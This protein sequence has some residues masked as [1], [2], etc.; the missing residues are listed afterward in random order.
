M[1]KRD[2]GNTLDV[3]IAAGLSR[4]SR[5]FYYK[6]GTKMFTN[7]CFVLTGVKQEDDFPSPLS[8]YDLMVTCQAPW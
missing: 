5:S 4:V 8:T 1:P 2:V 3:S 7:C 6:V